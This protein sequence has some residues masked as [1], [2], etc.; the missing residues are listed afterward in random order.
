ML[1]FTESKDRGRMKV[2]LC[3]FL[4]ASLLASAD[5]R[6]NGAPPEAC[7]AVS[8]NPTQHGAQPQTSTVPYMISGLPS[9]TD[10][11]PGAD[12]NREFI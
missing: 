1:W 7:A 4:V 9:A 10:Y 8:P 3:S 12:Y 11:T 6:S 2:A 5:C